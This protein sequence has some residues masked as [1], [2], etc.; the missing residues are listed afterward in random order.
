MLQYEAGAYEYSD[1]KAVIHG[2]PAAETVAAEA[3]RR[4]AR[5]VLVV[6]S[7]SLSRQTDAIRS[8]VA[9]LGPRHAGTFDDVVAHS[10][11]SCVLD[12]VGRIRA[13]DPDLI[14]SV[15]GGSVIDL[16]KV[17]RIADAAGAGDGPAVLA[18]RAGVDESGTMAPSPHPA[19]RCPHITVPTTMSGAEFGSVG[20]SVDPETHTKVAFLSRSFPAE[21]VIYDPAITL[22]TPEWLWLSTGIRAVDHAVEGIMSRA[23]SAYV[24]GL[25]LHA[26]RLLGD[27]LKAVS[28]R[29]DDLAARA[30]CQ[31]GVW[32]ASSGIMK[33]SYGASHGIGHQLGAVAGVPH[34]HTSCVM[35]PHVV[36]LNS[37]SMPERAEWVRMALDPAAPSAARALHDLIAGLGLPRTLDAVSVP[38]DAWQRIAES[39]LANPWVRS[40]PVPLRTADDVLALLGQANTGQVD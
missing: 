35:L 36:A 8:I 28:A 11:L 4:D 26:L 10:P 19:P 27:G 20:A 32:L 2:R 34:G 25:A 22:L 9:A 1:Q 15:G 18:I 17:A 5:R 16:V 23:P 3:A 37:P 30:T 7:R 13:L 39:A 6:A 40:N 24:D 38:R 29:P 31:L 33:V 21:T 12:L 14:L